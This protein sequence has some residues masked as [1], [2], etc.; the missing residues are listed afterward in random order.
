MA[1]ASVTF[2]GSRV[3]DA[4][5][6]TGWTNDGITAVLEGDFF[7]QGVSSISAQ[8]KT[9]EAGFYY[10]SGATSMTGRVWLCKVYSGKIGGLDGNGLLVRIGSSTANYHQYNLF[11]AA[12]YPT[13]GG[14]QLLAIDPNV[15][16]WRT[17]T[18]GTP[19][20]ASVI[21]WAVRADYDANSRAT[22]TAIDAIDHIASGA[23]LTIVGGDGADPDG[24][25]LSFVTADEGTAANRWSVVTSRAGIIY[26]LGTLSIGTATATVFTDA[27]RVLVFTDE[28]VTTGFCGLKFNLSNATNAIT[29]TNCVFNGRGA[30]YTADDTRPDY[31]VTGTSGTLSLSGCTFDGYRLVTL[32]SAVTASACIFLAGG[33]AI[34]AAGADLSGSSFSGF[35]G[36]ADTSVLSWDVA[37]DPDGLLD[38]TEFTKGTTATHAIEFGLTSPTTMTLRGIA[39]DG[40][41]AADA[42]NDSTL[43]IKRTTGT[44]TISLVGCSGNISYKTDGAT[45]VLIQD[46]VTVSVTAATSL[47]TPV[48]DVRVL[49]VATSG[50]P[51][52]HDATVTIS[53]SGTTATVTHTAHGLATGDKVQI[54]GASLWENNGVFEVTVTTPDAYTY[55]LPSA[56]GSSPTGTIK[57]AFVVLYGLTDVSGALSA[58]RV[59][60][61]SQ[62]FSGRARKSSAEPFYRTAPVVGTVSNTTGVT[63]TALMVPDQ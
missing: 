21:Y 62:P 58:T 17:S 54:K 24:D 55:T 52:F 31:T 7:Y 44:V 36:A 53:N 18:T 11:S 6:L 49:L 2:D 9:S 5:A 46:P 19:N 59:Y 42:N 3:T 43:Y 41:N 27:N 29:L 38:D 1:V 28:R 39:F 32:T 35:T 60:P 16:Q 13:V 10:T 15:S 20:L 33:A 12:T 25:F 51:F 22:N 61:S 63:A 23:G 8:I 57:A 30:L 47:G 45:V 34:V 48:Q 37:T 26:V 50:G 4:E 56:P 40:Y 14:W